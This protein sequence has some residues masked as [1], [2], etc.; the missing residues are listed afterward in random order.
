MSITIIILLS[1]GGLSFLG[2]ALLFVSKI[3]ERKIRRREEDKPLVESHKMKLRSPTWR[4]QK[5]HP[6]R[7]PHHNGI[8][9]K[10]DV[11][12]LDK[13]IKKSIFVCADCVSVVEQEELE[14]RDK[15]KK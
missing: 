14:Q 13:T 10:V 15:F 9:R 5:Y 8:Y 11:K 6:S 1:L 4:F 3:V 12:V 2:L 7:C